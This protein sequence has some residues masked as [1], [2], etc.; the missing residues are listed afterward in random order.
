MTS[1]P[2]LL[3]AAGIGYLLGAIP[4][5]VLVARLLGGEDPRLRGS[6]RTGATNVARTVGMV[7]AVVV[8][9]L[10]AAKGAAAVAI[11]AWLTLALDGRA[12]AEW[13][14]A[15]A[16]VAAVVGHVWSIFLRFRGG[17]GVATAAGGLAVIGPLALLA[18]APL[19]ALVVWRTRY[20]SLGSIVG[21]VG[22]PLL[23]A[24]LYSL[25]MYGLETVVY[26]AAAGTIVVLSH[27]DNL[28]R[29]RAGTERRLGDREAA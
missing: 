10:D 2:T 25:N 26:A 22:A 6:H 7:P 19:V 23:A 4:W 21:A 18:V 3:A 8:L 9:V 20:V 15:S 12:L 28:T 11:G 16:G 24:I 27:R 29:L 5:G 17:R 14:P 13:A 1:A